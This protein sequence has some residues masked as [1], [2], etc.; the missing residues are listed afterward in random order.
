MALRGWVISSG[1][2]VGN[3]FFFFF[4]ALNYGL[5]LLGYGRF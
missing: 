1:L 3:F 4:G 5:L 2:S